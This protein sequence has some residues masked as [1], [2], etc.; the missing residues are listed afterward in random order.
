ME[1]EQNFI[2][3]QIMEFA[4]RKSVHDDLKKYD[5]LSKDSGYVEVTE[6]VNGEGIDVTIES[7]GTKLISLTYGELD[8]INHLQNALRYEK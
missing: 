5:Y 6:W 1:K 7:G 2:K 3:K 8:A 4:S